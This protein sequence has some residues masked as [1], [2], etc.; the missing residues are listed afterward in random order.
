MDAG[1]SRET[2]R[3]LN[4]GSNQEA[5]NSREACNSKETSNTW[6]TM[7]MTE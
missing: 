5:R 2:S 1:I 6:T 3:A 4:A 7:T